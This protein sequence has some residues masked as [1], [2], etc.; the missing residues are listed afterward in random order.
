MLQQIGYDVGWKLFGQKSLEDRDWG[1]FASDIRKIDKWALTLWKIRVC[2]WLS[3][4]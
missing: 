3:K 4:R 2:K 1:D